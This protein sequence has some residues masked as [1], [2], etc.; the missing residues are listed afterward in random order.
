MQTTKTLPFKIYSVAW[1]PDGRHIAAAGTGKTVRIW[2]VEQE[3]SMLV[4][5]GHQDHV[6]VVAYSP[7]GSRLASISEDRTVRIWNPTTG[8][9]ILDFLC[10]PRPKNYG[11]W[12]TVTAL[13]WSPDGRRLATGAFEPFVR[14]WDAET[15]AALLSYQTPGYVIECTVWSPDGSQMATGIY[16]NPIEVWNTTD[17]TWRQTLKVGHFAIDNIAWLDDGAKITAAAIHPDVPSRNLML[18]EAATGRL[19]YSTP[20]NAPVAWSADKQ[21]LAY[22]GARQMFIL[23]AADG[24]IAQRIPGPTMKLA[25]LCWS[26]DGQHLVSGSADKT[27]RIWSR[28]R[29]S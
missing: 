14:L 5:R 9:T 17:G 21:F 12:P 1:S 8:E 19:C 3:R 28:E 24:T 29:S 16:G 13:A 2:D 18:W 10:T 26:P 6:R 23:N 25:A 15:G 22:P 20:C 4:C 11:G 7:D 27:A